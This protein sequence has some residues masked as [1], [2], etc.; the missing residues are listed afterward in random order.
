[1]HAVNSSRPHV[2]R[3]VRGLGGAHGFSMLELMIAM[4]IMG[5]VLA[6]TLGGLS[7]ATKA[8]AAV[9]NVTGMNGS[10]RAG[11]DLLVRDMLQVGSG[12]PPGHVLLT[13]SGTNSTAVRLPGPPGTT[14][15]MTAGDVDLGAVVPMPG[16]GPT[17]NG[18]ATDVLVTMMADN[19]F[20]N[21]PLTAMT[22][23]TVDVSTGLNIATG[24][25]R[26]SA[27]QLM[28]VQKGA[29]TTLLQVTSVN[30][31]NNRLTFADGD[32][33]NLN[34]SLAAAGNLTALNAADPANTPSACTISR[35]RMVT[36]YLDATTDPA[37]P[38]L[39]R[40][41]NNG[42]ATTFNNT[43]GNATAIDIENLQFSFDLVDGN[44]N[45]ANVR[46]TTADRN[47]TGSCAPNPCTEAQIRKVNIA[48][49]GRSQNAVNR[50][51]RAFRNTLVSQVS[52]RGM[53]FIDEYRAPAAP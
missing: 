13:P 23:T 15:T 53:A 18:V 10:L 32:S 24:P 45:P 34:Q 8:N 19:T 46:M 43:L 30:T 25:D 44:T 52:F 41:I 33:L 47:G 20:L 42:N 11:M 49:T 48:L 17:V 37:H 38:R 50:T 28:M 1:M 14:F 22:S 5:V 21:V 26:V 4:A 12:L 16:A 29:T 39:V 3:R 7:D 27:G 35:V 31:A 36:Y 9:L 51:Q 40:R 6:S 2:A